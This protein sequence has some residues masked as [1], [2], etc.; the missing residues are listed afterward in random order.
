[1]RD[2]ACTMSRFF[3]AFPQKSFEINQLGCKQ[4]PCDGPHWEHA[5]RSVLHGQGNKMFD[6]VT[7]PDGSLP[8]GVETTDAFA[9]TLPRGRARCCRQ[10]GRL[11]QHEGYE[12]HLPQAACGLAHRS[13]A[14]RHAR[15]RDGRRQNTITGCDGFGTDAQILSPQ[16][17]SRGRVRRRARIHWRGRLSPLISTR[18]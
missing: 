17:R 9:K 10:C 8:A 5:L 6:R 4:R 13:P 16:P 15:W 18:H 3:E 11:E 2:R 14:C 12:R 7:S 1:M